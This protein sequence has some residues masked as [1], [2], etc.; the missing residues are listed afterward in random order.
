[1]VLE[2]SSV[3][4]TPLTARAVL[5]HGDHATLTAIL[6]TYVDFIGAQRDTS[7]TTGNS[8]SALPALFTRCSHTR[9]PCSR[10]VSF[11]EI[12]IH[13]T[14]AASHSL[15]SRHIRRVSLASQCPFI[16]ARHILEYSSPSRHVHPASST[17]ASTSFYLLVLHHAHTLGTLDRD[18]HETPHTSS[19]LGSASHPSFTFVSRVHTST[20]TPSHSPQSERRC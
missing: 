16:F 17:A 7:H 20:R 4:T 3:V 15:G 2:S 6:H 9:A 11:A 14:S 12:S 10:R 1:M 13:A 19:S 5:H 8:S 18:R